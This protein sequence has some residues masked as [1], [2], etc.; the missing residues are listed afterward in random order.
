MYHTKFFKLLYKICDQYK[1]I[2]YNQNWIRLLKKVRIITS[3]NQIFRILRIPP[4]LNQSNVKGGCTR[5]LFL[6]A[7]KWSQSFIKVQNF[8]PNFSFTKY[9]NKNS[10]ARITEA[11]QLNFYVHLTFLWKFLSMILGTKLITNNLNQP[12]NDNF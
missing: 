9:D 3:Q 4:T 10:S 7:P 6:D 1:C 5:S 11:N 8:P 2:Y 12:Y